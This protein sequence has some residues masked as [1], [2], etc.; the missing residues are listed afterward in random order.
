M[1]RRYTPQITASFCRISMLAVLF[2]F[3]AGTVWGQITQR[4]TATS[5]TTTTTSLTVNKPG[6]V[7]AGDVMI[8]NITQ[9]GNTGTNA[10][11]SGWTLIAGARQDDGTRRSTILYRKAD[12][13]EGA[14]FT[15]SLGSGTTAAVGSIIAF[16]GVDPS[17][18]D[19]NPGSLSVGGST[20]IT[21]TGI[22]TNTNGAAVVFLAGASANTN[23]TYSNWTGTTPALTEIMD[24]RINSSVSV[25]AAWGIR[26]AAGATGNRSVTVTGN[27]YW[28]GILIAL[29]EAPVPGST[30]TETFNYT[31][32]TQTFT[33]PNCVTSVDVK[34]W[35]AGGGG[36]DRSG[37]GNDGGNGGGG[38]GFRGGSMA[39]SPGNTISISIGSG[40]TGGNGNGGD[41]TNGGNTTVTHTSGSITANGG[42]GGVVGNNAGGLGGA[43]G[44]GSFAGSVANQNGFSGGTGGVGDADEG[45]GGGGGAG[46]GQNGGNGDNGSASTHNGGSGGNNFGGNGGSG[47]DDGGGGDGSLFG[48]G[49]GACGDNGGNSVPGGN[50]AH[51]GVIITYTL[52]SIPT[53]T[54]GS[55]PSVAQGT[56]AA[57]L[58]YSAT[59]GCPDKYSIDWDATAEGQLFSDVNLANLP[60][61]PIVLAVPVGATPAT[62]NGTLTVT[63]STY[64][65][66]S[67]T[68]NIEVTVTAGACILTFTTGPGNTN[69]SCFSGSDGT[70]QVTITSPDNN[71]YTFS[72]DNGT[73]YNVTFTGSYPNYTLTGLSEGTHQIRIKDKNGCE[74]AVCP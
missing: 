13:S 70:I 49:G 73:T 6:G 5:G 14:S 31:G 25:G 32:T 20:T 67:A 38:G 34:A 8:V 27:Y 10:S 52:P 57:N 53:I 12:G 61:S 19:V 35:G 68:Y 36:S 48:G 30:I 26:A 22:T 54:L 66:V 60:A 28:A 29:K 24:F 43:G 65:F 16:S 4:G 23:N 11:L 55:N 42:D 33:V 45:G 3:L 2:T 56:T 47:G 59:T 69:I 72:R 46:D 62:Y 44:G 63:N 15:F 40:G 18:F 7:I 74:S 39:V 1:K 41:G 51:G 71:P 50:G 21:A 58:T 37:N 17:V 9:N 64:G